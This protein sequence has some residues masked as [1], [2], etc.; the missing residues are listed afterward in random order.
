MENIKK[1]IKENYGFLLKDYKMLKEGSIQKNYLLET[2]QGKFVLK[3]YVRDRSLESVMFEVEVVNFLEDKDFPTSYIIRNNNNESISYLNGTPSILYQYFTGIHIENMSPL[4][5]NQL[6]KLVA[7]LNKVTN[8]FKPANTKDRWNYEENSWPEVALKIVS[9]SKRED[10][11]KKYEYLQKELS[12]L[13]FSNELSKG[14]VHCDFHYTNIIFENEEIKVLIDFDDSNYSYL[15]IDLAFLINP[16]IKDYN[17]NTWQN[18]S[19]EDDVFD[20][21]EAKQIVSLYSNTRPLSEEEKTHLYDAYKLTI[22][23]DALWY[24]E[25][26]EFDMFYEKSKL[27]YLSKLGRNNF[28]KKIFS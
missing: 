9:E 17:W 28:K 19:K 6:V 25:R 24:F 13:Q 20:F 8:N 27:E 18:F 21:T 7:K 4:Q 2:N 23:F 5:F 3:Q 10:K 22:L 16:F 1:F 15:V 12:K 26:G 14:I 11:M